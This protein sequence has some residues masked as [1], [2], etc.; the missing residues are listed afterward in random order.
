MNPENMAI[1][2]FLDNFASLL[3]I[4]NRILSGFECLIPLLSREFLRAKPQA[5]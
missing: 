4:V 3:R 2:M 5:W 1:G